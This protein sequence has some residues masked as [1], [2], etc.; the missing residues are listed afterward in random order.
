MCSEG[1]EYRQIPTKARDLPG[2]KADQFPIFEAGVQLASA[3]LGYVH[4]RIDLLKQSQPDPKFNEFYVPVLVTNARLFFINADQI[5]LDLDTGD[6]MSGPNLVKVS[7]VIL[8]QPAASPKNFPDFRISIATDERN[9]QFHESIYVINAKSL[10]VFFA[11][12][13]RKFLA[14]I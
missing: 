12:D 6:V 8:K 5:E 1:Y 9:Q 11:Q 3:F 10:G 14:S 7:H 4:D 2:K 13:H